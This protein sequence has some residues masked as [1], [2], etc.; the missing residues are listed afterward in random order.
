MH[1]NLQKKE[2]LPIATKLANDVLCLPMYA[3][4]KKNEVNQIIKIIN[5]K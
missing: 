3:D 4:L 2:N 1:W 5:K